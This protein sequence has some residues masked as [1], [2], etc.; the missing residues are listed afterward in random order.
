MASSVILG[1]RTGSPPFGP[2]LNSIKSKTRVREDKYTVN[3]DIFALYIF[4]RFSNIR[5][6]MYTLKIA[7]MASYT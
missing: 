1:V 5:G 3:V 2:A 4:L 7:K 6:N